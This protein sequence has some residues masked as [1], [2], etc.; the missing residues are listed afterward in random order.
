MNLAQRLAALSPAKR[1]AALRALPVADAEALLYDWH[2]WARADQLPPPGDWQTWVMLS[3]RGAGKTRAGA[4]WV[5]GEIESGRRRSMALVAPTHMA[6]RKVLIEGPSGILACCPRWAMPTWEIATGVLRWPNGGLA[7]LV[8]SETPDRI[9][10]FNF[11]GAWGDEFSSWE[12]IA[13]T[14]SQ[15]TL[16]LRM[17]GPLGH[18]PQVVLTT[19]PKPL[20]LLKMLLAET[21]TVVTR[22]S[23]FD[24]AANLSPAA[25]A[26]LRKRYEGTS[27]GRQELFG[28][29]LFEVDGALWQRDWIDAARVTEAPEL[30]RLVVA[31]DPAVSSGAASA[32][33]GIVAAGRAASGDVYVLCDYS[34]RGT[35]EAWAQRAVAAYETHAA[36]AIVAEVNQGGALVASV[37]QSVGAAQVTLKTVHAARGKATRAEPVSAL[38][39][40][41]RV[42]HVGSLPDLEAQLCGW[43][44]GEGASPDRLDALVWAVTEL[45]LGTRRA[46]PEWAEAARNWKP[47]A[48][49]N[50]YV[51]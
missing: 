21:G 10:G 23:T 38:Y 35:P 1:A 11:D 44:P 5:R 39:Q 13:E 30:V 40:Q 8:S 3:G 31:V 45:A 36:D 42:H 51:R 6:G 46:A 50:L 19:T 27:V 28:E 18:N 41:G 22:A 29:L 4:E 20:P 26:A 16:A 12:N 17:P 33:T 15:L 48:T 43:V 34:L 2:T 47:P 37:L 7:H 9:R 32:E 25:L 49:I 24:N 14:W